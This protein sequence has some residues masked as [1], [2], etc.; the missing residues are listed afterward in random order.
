SVI[1]WQAKTILSKYKPKV[2]AI[3]GSVGKTST[4]DAVYLVLTNFFTVRKSQKSFNSEIGVPLTIIGCGSGW[5]SAYLWLKNI[6]KGFSLIIFK[7][8]YP[9]WLVLEVGADRPGDIKSIA[10]WLKPDVVV[11]TRISEVPV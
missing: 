11:I 7:H 5:N 1:S 6:L 10:K 2:V 4:K 9:E 3:T 8:K